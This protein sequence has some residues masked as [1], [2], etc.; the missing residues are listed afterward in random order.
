MRA[1]LKRVQNLPNETANCATHILLGTLPVEA[2]L[3]SQVMGLFTRI[4]HLQTSREKAIILRQ[5]SLKDLNSASW[6][7]KVRRI[8]RKYNLPTPYDLLENPPTKEK[9]CKTVTDAIHKYWRDKISTEASAKS[10]LKYLNCHSYVPG[11]LHHIWASTEPNHLDIKKTQLKAR[12]L[13]GRYNLQTN[14]AKFK[15]SSPTCYLC[16]DEDE[17][18]THFLLRCP[19]LQHTRTGYLR[20]L[21]DLL[22][23]ALLRQYE[24]AMDTSTTKKL[25]TKNTGDV[26]TSHE[27]VCCLP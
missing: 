4:L 7:Q 20:Q 26:T 6:T 18:L 12:L 11:Q 25:K 27:D 2:K 24:D 15:N 14:L 19:K 10:T 16:L 1:M 5:L 9:W 23:V 21:K 17:D 13:V 8:L 3:D 22:T